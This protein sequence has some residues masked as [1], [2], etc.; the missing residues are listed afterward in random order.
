M[1]AETDKTE[2]GMDKPEPARDQLNPQAGVRDWGMGQLSLTGAGG[3]AA[4]SAADS[5]ILYDDSSSSSCFSPA[6]NASSSDALMMYFVVGARSTVKI[7]S[8]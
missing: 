7:P 4:A 8:R 1:E 3:A 2:T 5:R 6:R